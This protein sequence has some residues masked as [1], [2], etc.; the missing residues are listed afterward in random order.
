MNTRKGEGCRVLIV[1]F[2]IIE[3]QLYTYYKC[4]MNFTITLMLYLLFKDQE[5]KL[6]ENFS[7]SKT[8]PKIKLDSF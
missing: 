4:R 6:Q 2:K 3:F 8:K 1:I 7:L 5:I